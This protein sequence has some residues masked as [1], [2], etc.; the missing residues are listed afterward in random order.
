MA[1]RRGRTSAR[2][3][4]ALKLA[5][6]CGM[7]HLPLDPTAPGDRATFRGYTHVTGAPAQ[8]TSL[9]APARPGRLGHAVLWVA[10]ST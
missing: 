4:L 10:L 7:R 9:G 3:H 2:G 5:L 8:P 6:L 1:A